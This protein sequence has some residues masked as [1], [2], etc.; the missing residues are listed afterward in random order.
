M[1]IDEPKTEKGIEV[2]EEKKIE[3]PQDF[4]EFIPITNIIDNIGF[5]NPTSSAPTD[6]PKRPFDKFRYYSNG[7]TYRLYIY[8]SV[9]KAWRYVALT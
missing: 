6:T 4:Q 2:I 3:T 9:G 8:D 1:I 5:L 7:G